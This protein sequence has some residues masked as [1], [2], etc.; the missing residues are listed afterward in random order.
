MVV[1]EL[2]AEAAGPIPGI[3]RGHILTKPIPVMERRQQEDLAATFSSL[4]NRMRLGNGH[5]EMLCNVKSTL[6]SDL[7]SGR[8]RVPA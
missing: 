5:M 7:L 4:R 1:E 2:N 6:M 3:T 8:V